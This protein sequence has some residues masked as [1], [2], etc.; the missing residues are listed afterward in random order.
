MLVILCVEDL[1]TVDLTASFGQLYQ[2]PGSMFHEW[3]ILCICCFF[4]F[5]CMVALQCFLYWRRL[6]NLTH[7]ECVMMM[8]G[9]FIC[10]SLGW[11]PSHVPSG[12]SWLVWFICSLIF[13]LW[14]SPPSF[15]SVYVLLPLVFQA[16]FWHLWSLR[17]LRFLSSEWS[18]FHQMSH[19]TWPLASDDAHCRD[20]IPW[21][22]T[23]YHS[24][25]SVYTA[26]RFHLCHSISG[27]SACPMHLNTSTLETSG[28]SPYYLSYG[29]TPVLEVTTRFCM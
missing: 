2:L 28:F 20:D 1:L 10:K 11:N 21:R 22:Q 7:V 25:W 6:V 3:P 17:W 19:L 29:V 15:P 12:S 26:L 14:S 8:I 9:I 18:W 23:C 13:T 5:P 27:T 4:P 24:P 16:P